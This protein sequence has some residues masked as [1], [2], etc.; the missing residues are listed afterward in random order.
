MVDATCKYKR[1]FQTG[2]MQRS[3]PEFRQVVELVRN[4][5]IGEIKTVKVSVGGPPKP[6]DLPGEIVPEGLD[7]NRWLGPNQYTPFHS[8]LAPP[9]SV[10]V[11]PHWRA[12]KEFGG[13]GMTDWGAH[14]FD[15]V[16]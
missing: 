3:W 7:W 6:F 2:S 12:Y 14:M 13:G 8:E 5:Y 4:G 16:Q 9:L 11:F 15:I 10:D 1:V